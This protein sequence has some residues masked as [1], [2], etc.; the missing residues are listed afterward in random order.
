MV[1]P[2]PE[3]SDANADADVLSRLH[4]ISPVQV[5]AALGVDS[6]VGLDADEVR[7]RRARF[8]RNELPRP[9]K[10]HPL[11]RVLAQFAD[12]LVGALLVAAVVA[13]VVAASEAGG[14]SGLA[15]YGDTAAILL[16]VILNA[17]LGF[18]QERKAERALDALEK[19][20]APTARVV[21]NKKTSQ[22]PGSDL[23]P[24]DILELEAGDSV[25]ADARVLTTAELSAEESPLTGE[26]EPVLK[27][28]SAA[29]GAADP[30]ADQLTMVFMGTS[31]VRGHARALV[32]RTGALTELGK[33]GTLIRSARTKKTPLEIQIAK[34]SRIIL[35]ICLALSSFLFAVGWIQGNTAWT[36]LLLTAVSLA[37]A[38]IPEGLPA[39]TTITLAIGMQRM[40]ERGAIVRRLPAVETLGSA[41]IICTDKTGTLTQNA[42]T[43]R[44]LETADESFDITGTGYDTAGDI[45][46]QGVPVSEPSTALAALVRASVLCNTAELA[47]DSEAN[48][49]LGDPMEAALLV[50]GAKAGLARADV[51]E[52]TPIERVVPFDS[53]RMLMTV[54]A[55][56]ADGSLLA[57]VKGSPEALLQRCAHILTTQ[58][59]AV[60][61]EAGRE[62]LRE[63]ADEYADR[64]L[65]VLAVANHPD[66]GTAPEEALTFLGFVAM[67][68]PPRPEAK[69]AISACHEAGIRI[70]M[71]TGDH[72][73]TA[74]AI[75]GELDIWREG[76]DVMTGSELAELDGAA[77]NARVAGVSVFARITPE[78]KLRIVRAL[79]GRGEIVAM[80]G[81]GVNDAP[82]LKEAHIGVAMGRQGTDVAREAADLVLA[83]DNFATIVAAVREGRSIF[84][85]IQ[86]FVFF[87]NSSNAGLAMAVI[88]G[89]FFDWMPALTPI[90]LLWINLV[91]NGLPALALGVDPPS[92]R[93]MHERPRK[94]EAGIFG[95]REGAGVLFVGSIMACS[96]LLI[97]W[98]PDHAPAL[99]GGASKTAALHIARTMAFALL[100]FAPLVHAFNA[101]SAYDSI[102]TLGWFSNPL[103]WV[104]VI[105]SGMIQ[106][107]T[108]AIPALRGVFVTDAL[109]PIQWWVVVALALIPLPAVELAKGVARACQRGAPNRADAT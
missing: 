13:A 96:A 9:P 27:D 17:G 67:Q 80:T 55:R 100:A 104:A 92:E 99:F 28:A 72:P 102:W 51:L 5:C 20:A 8:G 101:R 47:D 61:D 54:V 91:T 90:Q 65:R 21:R 37:V 52:T 94:A 38:A 83:D 109:T 6:E 41:T 64:G 59:P 105:V 1:P 82:A 108:I 68:D 16:I 88:I 69:A 60:L 31:I 53:E 106:L 70:A 24:G 97:F 71:V 57:H 46:S 76:D 56:L 77:L 45:C 10:T 30:T 81:D 11:I 15:R 40:A 32:V 84:W 12:P 4:A 87:L 48:R 75:A 78:Q 44:H 73:R 86:K 33:I 85:N 74:V 39:I 14:S 2:V 107:C 35:A 95:L 49:A 50:L 62:K 26:S 42:M 25:P 98:L 18:F 89:S 79:Q 3:S 58:G 19:M 23:V 29:V 66:P 7:T 63:R 43:V 93:Q 34:L 103:L 36:V 22:V